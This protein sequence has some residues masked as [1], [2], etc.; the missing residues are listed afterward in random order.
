MIIVTLVGQGSLLPPVIRVLGLANAGAAEAA[1]NKTAEIAA[2]IDGV[3]AVLAELDRL[4][5]TGAPEGAVRALRRRHCDRRAEFDGTASASVGGNPVAED[6]E[7]QGLLIEAERHRIG[8]L[9]AE[10]RITDDARRRIEREL[11]LENA[12]NLHALESATG[13][14]LADPESETLEG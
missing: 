12:R 1:R 10:G 9:Y 6:A 7:L 5:A 13:D 11:D 14:R 3:A 4:E 8:E 2:R